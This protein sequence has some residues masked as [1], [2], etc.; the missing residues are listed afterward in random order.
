VNDWARKREQMALAYLEWLAASARLDP[1]TLFELERLYPGLGRYAK[2]GE[3]LR[4][5]SAEQLRAIASGMVLLINEE[6]LT[7]SLSAVLPAAAGNPREL[8][9]QLLVAWLSRPVK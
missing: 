2:L 3:P 5:C 8:E 4:G 7:P 6:D 9:R 1:A